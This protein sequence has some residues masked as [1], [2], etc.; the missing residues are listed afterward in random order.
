MREAGASRAGRSQAGAWERGGTEVMRLLLQGHLDLP[1]RV[2]L[3]VVLKD[4]HPTPYKNY[5]INFVQKRTCFCTERGDACFT[6]MHAEIGG[7]WLTIELSYRT[8]IMK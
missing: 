4:P 6:A 8:S 7:V 5:Y 3:D 2:T 1:Q